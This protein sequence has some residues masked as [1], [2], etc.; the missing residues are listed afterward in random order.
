[1][2]VGFTPPNVDPQ[3]LSI[4]QLSELADEFVSVKALRLKRVVDSASSAQSAALLVALIELR[5]RLDCEAALCD[6]RTRSAERVMVG[7]GLSA[8][9]AGISLLVVHETPF[10]SLAPIAA[11]MYVAWRGHLKALEQVE[12]GAICRRIV[13]VLDQMI[14]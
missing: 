6:A 2:A 1:M 4:K 12:R 11:G 8:I 5:G 9:L 13:F 10:I 7:G 3:K 14:G